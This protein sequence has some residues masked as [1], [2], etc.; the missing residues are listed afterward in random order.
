[1]LITELM[2]AMAILVIAVLPIGYSLLTDARWL[3]SNYQHAISIEVVDGE[4]EILRAGEWRSFP[5]GTHPYTVH[6][7]AAANLPPGQFQ[8]TRQGQHLRLQWK[9]DQPGHG[10]ET[11]VREVTLK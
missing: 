1:M 5:E 3:K 4:M 6:A 10:L 7:A 8:L 11:V 9:P 2:V